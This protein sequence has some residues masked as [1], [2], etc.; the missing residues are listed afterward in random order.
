MDK[1]VYNISFYHIYPENIQPVSNASDIQITDTAYARIDIGKETP[2]KNKYPDFE[3]SGV[4]IGGIN[5]IKW[6]IP[7]MYN[8]K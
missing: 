6:T 3:S 7:L 4:A 5:Y 8:Q 2:I 1:N